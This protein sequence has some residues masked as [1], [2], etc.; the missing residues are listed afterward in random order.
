MSGADMADRWGFHSQI[1]MDIEQKFK[2]NFTIGL[3]AGFIFG[4]QLRDTSI[5]SDLYN[6]FGTIT[7]L[8]GS[9]ADV[10]FLMRG[11][12]GHFTAGYVINRFGNNPNSGIWVKAGLGWMMHKIRIESLYDVVPQL[13]GDYR[14]GYDKLTTGFSTM[15]FVGYLYQADWRLIKLYAGFEFI[16]GFT[17]NV[18]TYNF[19]TGGPETE[20]R[21]DLLTGF[22]VGWIMPISHRTR[23]EYYFD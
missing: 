16:Q 21:I 5:F 12:T 11:F 15:Q 1:G 3:G 17:R 4:N 8:S 2:S 18:R 13:Q 20:S 7:G 14:Q 10:L 19:D 22:K 9:P 23:S 6:S